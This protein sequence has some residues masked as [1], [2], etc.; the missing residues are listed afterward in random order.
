MWILILAILAIITRY[1]FVL[2]KYLKTGEFKKKIYK[3]NILGIIAH[4]FLT[5][6]IISFL[7]FAILLIKDRSSDLVMWIIFGSGLVTIIMY[8]WFWQQRT[9]D[10]A[11][12]KNIQINQKMNEEYRLKYGDD[13][14]YTK[15][16]LN[17]L[18][19]PDDSEINDKFNTMISIITNKQI[20]FIEQN[21]YK[22]V[23]EVFSF[24]CQKDYMKLSWIND[25]ISL[26]CEGINSLLKNNNLNLEIKLED[27]IKDDD[28]FIK[29]R[30]R[31]MVST[32]IYDLNKINDIIKNRLKNYEI[33]TAHIYNDNSVFFQYPIYLCVLQTSEFNDFIDEN[34]NKESNETEDLI[35]EQ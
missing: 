33:I 10:N 32:L 3:S 26:T 4:S 29:A 14:K 8:L 6:L 17:Y 34:E 30:R 22:N 15:S 21:E 25:S 9:Y 1:V 7:I 27:I 35:N 12:I 13:E 5:I 2:K 19:I 20:S 16:K 28:E 18:V 24:L 11:R 23:S 31:D